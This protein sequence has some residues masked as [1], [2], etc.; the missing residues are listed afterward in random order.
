MAQYAMR[1]LL[2]AAFLLA[3]S[4]LAAQVSASG[5]IEGVIIDSVHMRPLANAFVFA[6]PLAPASGM[7]RTAVTDD[8]G[9]YRIDS[10]APDRY[11]VDFTHPLL[12]SLELVPATHVVTLTD[13][14]V[15]RLDFGVPSGRSLR[16]AAC[17]GLTLGSGQGAL[18]GQLLRAD[19]EAPMAGASVVVSW[20]EI[21]L[22]RGLANAYA[23]RAVNTTS[24]VNGRYRLCGLPTGI[25]LAV[26]LQSAARAGSVIRTT[27]ADSAGLAVLN[28]SFS[29][30][31]SYATTA[32]DS[33]AAPEAFLT[34]T[35]ALSG[36]VRGTGGLPVTGAQ[37]RVSDAEPA[38]RTDMVGHF[39]LA[40]LPAGTQRLE[41]R[42]LGYLASDQ[43]VSLR[44]GR[45]EVLDVQLVRVV[46][47][48]SVR[49]V[50]QRLKYPE[51]ERRARMG[52][53]RYLRASD[54]AARG[55]F[56]VSSIIQM[57]PGFRVEGGFTNPRIYTTRSAFG[58]CEVNV[59]VDGLQAMDIL[60]VRPD[61][62]AAMEFYTSWAGAPPGYRAECGLILIWTKR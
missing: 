17:P 12:D 49:I 35:A 59:V 40:N 50:A 2:F 24:S 30:S 32:N 55:A 58:R 61:Q 29:T 23:L 13:G 41:V 28:L 39:T 16:A 53:G 4:P 34:G 25:L 8:R 19:D 6:R 38:T 20:T 15:A 46:S 14:E 45:T 26:Q 10:L 62:I 47:L 18:V 1:F 31:A 5:R 22:A 37:V 42:R 60:F 54:I 56:D 52:F 33:V 9:R 36:T 43:P 11:A 48:D 21:D 3:P 44:N 7:G 51:F 57:T 27:I